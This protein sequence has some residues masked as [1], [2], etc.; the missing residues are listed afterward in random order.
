MT[1]GNRVKYGLKQGGVLASGCV[2]GLIAALSFAGCSSNAGSSANVAGS[3]SSN[4]GSE[5]S[6]GGSSAHGGAT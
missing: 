1:S 2:A 6:N 4:A 5:S 3:E